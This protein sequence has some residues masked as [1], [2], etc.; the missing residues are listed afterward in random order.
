[1]N[2]SPASKSGVRRFAV[3]GD[4]VAHSLSPLIHNSWIKSHGLSATYEAIR[5]GPESPGADI[6]AMAH[7]FGGL[8]VT[9][10]HKIAAL[11]ASTSVSPLA[12]R[13]GAANTLVN[14]GAGWEAHNTD[15]EG[16]EVAARL[17]TGQDLAGLSVVLIGAGGAARAAAVCLSDAGA[18]LTIVNRSEENARML[19]RELAPGAAIAGLD[20][21]ASVTRTAHLVVNSASLGHSGGSL[22]A[23]APGD[24]RPFL[25]LSYGRAAAGVLAEAHRAGWAPFDGLPMLV[26]QAAAAFR[27][28]FGIAPDQAETLAAC[29]RTVAARA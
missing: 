3:V 8:N 17:A 19:V 27:L 14:A 18:R 2:N 29:R 28:W 7:D 22:P 13:V 11:E 21:L 10:P 25:D 23:L 15:V 20:Q 9:L 12:R 24:A 26:A 4:P 5:I 6:R 16:F 1:M